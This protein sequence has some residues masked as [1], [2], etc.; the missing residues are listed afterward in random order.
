MPS[1]FETRSCASWSFSAFSASAIRNLWRFSTRF[2]KALI[3][4][5]CWR[6]GARKAVDI[7]LTSTN[8]L[9]DRINRK[10]LEALSGEEK[11]FVGTL[12]GKMVYQRER[13][14]VPEELKLKVGAQVMFVRN[15]SR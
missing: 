11:V 8:D 6:E 2:G 3:I 10:S 12:H 14:P 1:R 5:P 9:A 15:K 4:A 13:L 7:T